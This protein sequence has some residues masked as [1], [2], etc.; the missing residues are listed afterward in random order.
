VDSIIAVASESVLAAEDQ[1]II[2]AIA[3]TNRWVIRDLTDFMQFLAQ[4]VICWDEQP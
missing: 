1:L 2:S 3:A 4:N